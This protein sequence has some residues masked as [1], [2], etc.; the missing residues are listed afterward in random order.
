MVTPAASL[1]LWT[2]EWLS[3]RCAP[4][5]VVDAMRAWAP[6]QTIRAGHQEA[7]GEFG[8]PLSDPVEPA[9]A[10]LLKLLRSGHGPV[11]YV[12]PVPGDVRGLPPGTDF[13]RVALEVGEGV[14][15]GDVGAVAEAAGNGIHW[16]VFYNGKVE[17][18]DYLTTDSLTDAEARMDRA[19]SEATRALAQTMSS[20][21]WRASG[22][23]RELVM[24]QLSGSVMHDL[25]PSMPP[26]AQRLLRKADHVAAILEVATTHFPELFGATIADL[27]DPG[28]PGSARRNP[29]SARRWS[30]CR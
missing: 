15:A 9:G 13:A 29:L 25:P 8:L 17:V 24:S 6:E 21:D 16:R 10:I 20:R 22:N 7:S 30:G 14:V 11:R 28:S 2:A 12:R 18:P 19:M 26:R 23:V 5:D 27:R 1:A 4:D 3:G